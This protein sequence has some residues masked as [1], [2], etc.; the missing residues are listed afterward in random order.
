MN[1][2]RLL[3]GALAIGQFPG[4]LQLFRHGDRMPLN[5]TGLAIHTSAAIGD[6]EQSN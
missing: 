1:A 4:R 6:A 2:V 3:R 5:Q